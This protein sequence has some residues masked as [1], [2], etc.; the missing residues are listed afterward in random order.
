MTAL[1]S[2][3]R[4]LLADLRVQLPRLRDQR[5]RERTKRAIRQIE[6]ELA[7]GRA[8]AMEEATR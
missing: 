2:Q 1:N 4:E 6:H 3:R 8:R 5:A 7:G